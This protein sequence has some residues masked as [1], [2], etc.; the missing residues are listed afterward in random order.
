MKSLFANSILFLF[1]I[2]LTNDVFRDYF[3]FAEIEMISSF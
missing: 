3:N 1:A 2:A